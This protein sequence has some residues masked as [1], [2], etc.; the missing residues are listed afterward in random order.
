MIH[1]LVMLELLFPLSPPRLECLS[2]RGTKGRPCSESRTCGA[3]G[4]HS[5]LALIRA[6]CAPSGITLPPHQAEEQ[7]GT[8][9][10]S[11]GCLCTEEC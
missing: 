3:H 9:G 10:I 1:S 11:L 2:A 8:E 5:G 4:E 7:A 6:L